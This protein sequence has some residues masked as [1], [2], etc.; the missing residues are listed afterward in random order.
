MHIFNT[1]WYYAFMKVYFTASTAEFSKYKDVYFRIRQY[2]IDNGYIL[3]RDWLPHTNDRHTKK[4]KELRDIKEI[5]KACIDAIYKADV[6][7]VED[8][9]SNFSTGHQI[10]MA[11]QLDKPVLVLWQGKKY[12]E[13][14][15]VFIHGIESTKL[16]IVEYDFDNLEDVLHEFLKKYE[17][18]NETNRFNLVLSGHER[19]YLDYVHFKTGKSR[20]QVIKEALKDKMDG[21]VGYSEYLN[22]GV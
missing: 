21:D 3:T 16:E 17:N 22:N 8:T 2:L 6:V 11:L 18:A 10:T 14:N 13:F 1:L 20:T 5:Y 9:V 19:R 4:Q 7:I 12:R 15:Q